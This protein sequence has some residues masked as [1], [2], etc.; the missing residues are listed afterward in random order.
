MNE[1]LKVGM[2]FGTSN[3][4]VGAVI[5]GETH[6]FEARKG[7]LSQPSSIFIRADG[8]HS[9]GYKAIEDFVDPGTKTDNYHFVPSVKPGLPLEHYEGIVLKS[10]ERDMEGKFPIIDFTVQEMATFV[11]SD[12]K[13]KAEEQSNH[14]TREVVMG[15]PVM[16]SDDSKM[17]KLAQTRLEKAARAAGFES[18][19]FIME[20]IAAAL[21]YERSRRGTTARNVFIFDFGGGTLDTC[22]LELHPEQ[23]ITPKG[24]ETR[25]LAS[26][27]VDLGGMDLDK[28]VFEN[29]YLKYFGQDVTWGDKNLAMP[30]Y[31]YHDIPEWHLIDQLGKNNTLNF[32]KEIAN[33]STD[34]GAVKRLITLIEDQQVFATLQSIEQGK[35]ELSTENKGRIKHNYKNIEI[36]DSILTDDFNKAIALR[37]L[38]I[39]RCIEECLKKAGFKSNQ[40]DAVLKVGGSSNNAFTNDILSGFFSN[41]VEDGNVFTSVVT[42]LSIAA[43]EIFE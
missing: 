27:G 19:F 22:I 14:K 30:I 4:S 7:R 32:L 31:I 34:P 40:V 17:D 28:D 42:G 13:Q 6:I 10:T 15:R 16:F 43:S 39:T 35:I 25:V 8:Y 26:H 23:K 1:R 41:K 21:Y 2:D 12:L 18:V 3:S 9:T 29:R 33:G 24:L 36:E 20:P 11:I 5:D 38:E 37:R